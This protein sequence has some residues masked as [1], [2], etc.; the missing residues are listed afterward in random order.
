M[1]NIFLL[2]FILLAYTVF[3][4]G[5]TKVREEDFYLE[6][7]SSTKTV[8]IKGNAM[9]VQEWVEQYDNP[10]SSMPSA[11]KEIKKT[12]NISAG[13]IS[14]LKSTIK[15]NGF[16]SLP[17]TEYG[18]AQGDRYYPYTISVVLN[19]KQKKILY[20]S[21]PSPETEQAPKAFSELEKQ[22][23]EMTALIK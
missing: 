23:N 6:Y 8:I 12:V 11:R 19:G 2:S 16:M 4:Q 15:A 18:A 10:V 3:A 14:R 13:D 7:T 20:K 17:K 21:N 5:K 1:K 22:V 9:T